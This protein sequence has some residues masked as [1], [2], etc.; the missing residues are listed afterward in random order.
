MRFIR[1]GI[2]HYNLDHI[3]YIEE[4]E[5]KLIISY[6]INDF[7]NRP[8]AFQASTMSLDFAGQRMISCSADFR[9]LQTA[10]SCQV[11]VPTGFEPVF[12]P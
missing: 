4:L 7:N 9:G 6:A 10:W 3:A 2:R 12:M 1:R 5:D 8:I 11:V